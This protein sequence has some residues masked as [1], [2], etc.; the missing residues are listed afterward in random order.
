MQVCARSN[1]CT[2][3]FINTDFEQLLGHFEEDMT[4]VVPERWQTYWT[5]PKAKAPVRSPRGR[6]QQHKQQQ[7]QDEQ[8]QQ[9]RWWKRLAG[10]VELVRAA[11]ADCSEAD[12]SREQLEQVG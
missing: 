7:H 6:L 3:T 10:M 9:E 12:V 8:E 11:A 1:I 5:G 4:S 2:P